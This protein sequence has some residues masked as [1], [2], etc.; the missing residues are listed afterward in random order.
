MFGNPEVE[1]LDYL[2][3]IRDYVTVMRKDIFPEYS[4]IQ[5]EIDAV[6]TLLD[7]TIYRLTFLK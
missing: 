5:N 2:E 6:M 7:S 1:P 3:S 4:N